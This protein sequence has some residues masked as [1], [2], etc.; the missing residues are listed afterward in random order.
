MALG[1]RTGYIDL[2]EGRDDAK[3][4]FTIPSFFTRTEM[5]FLMEGSFLSGMVGGVRERT[6][7][8]VDAPAL[9]D[10]INMVVFEFAE[11]AEEAGE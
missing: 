4:S 11:F 5:A 10:V 6:R 8:V 7:T 9:H 2:Q 3:I 1:V